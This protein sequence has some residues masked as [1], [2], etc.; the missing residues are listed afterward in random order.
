MG[1]FKMGKNNF[2]YQVSPFNL[3]HKIGF[4]TPVSRMVEYG[5]PLGRAIEMSGDPAQRWARG[6]VQ[7]A[8]GGMVNPKSAPYPTG[9]YDVGYVK[10]Q[11]PQ[12]NQSVQ[13]NLALQP[14][15]PQNQTTKTQPTQF[16]MPNTSGI[17]FGGI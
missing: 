15:T 3:A 9:P 6:K 10:P 14:A 1:G 11:T 17:T 4:H 2:L 5:E 16:T 13:P 8:W 7:E 12:K